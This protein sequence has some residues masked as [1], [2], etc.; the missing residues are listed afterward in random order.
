LSITYVDSDTNFTATEKSLVVSKPANT[1]DNDLM[2][3]VG[4]I[5]HQTAS[6]NPPDGWN[7]IYS[8]A[9]TGHSHKQFVWYKIASSEGSDYTF[10]SSSASILEFAVGIST[11]R[12]I[13]IS[14]A[15][16]RYSV[17][18]TNVTEFNHIAP[19]LTTQS[20]N[21]VVLSIA[22]C[23]YGTVYT[24]TLGVPVYNECFD[25]NSGVGN[26]R[27]SITL[28]YASYV[29]IS[30]T[31][32]IGP[33]AEDESYYKASLVE[34]VLQGNSSSS[35]TSS[36]SSSS[37]SKNPSSSSSS[38]TVS[39]SSS[40]K[41][42]SSSSKSLSSSSSSKSSIS[43]SSS[44]RSSS[45][46]YSLSQFGVT[47]TFDKELSL[48]IGDETHYLYGQ[49]ANDD[50]W[51][52]SDTG[53]V[54]I[55]EISPAKT[56]I[57]Q[58]DPY[59]VGI[60][61]VDGTMID[62]RGMSIGNTGY[63]GTSGTKIYNLGGL[64]RLNKISGWIQHNTNDIV[65]MKFTASGYSSYTETYCLV[66]KID[67]DNVTLK[68]MDGVDI[69]YVSAST[70]QATTAQGLD[71]R[72]TYFHDAVSIAAP[73][74]LTGLH[75]VVTA[76]S[77]RFGEPYCPTTSGNSPRPAIKYNAVLT[78]VE[79]IPAS[80]EFR[81]AYCGLSTGTGAKITGLNKS[82]MSGL[83]LPSLPIAGASYA[84]VLSD[85]LEV[86]KRPWLDFVTT[87]SGEDLLGTESCGAP[88]TD[89]TSPTYARQ[90]TWREGNVFM[91]LLLDTSS[92]S[93]LDKN[94]LAIQM[95]QRGIDIYGIITNGGGWGNIGG[96]IGQ[97]RKLPVLFAGVALDYAPFKNVGV[98]HGDSA[99]TLMKHCRFMEDNQKF[100]ISEDDIINL[101][102][103]SDIITRTNC[104]VTEV[105]FNQYLVTDDDGGDFSIADD[106]VSTLKKREDSPLNFDYWL[107][108]GYESPN[109]EY[110]RVYGCDITDD[111]YPSGTGLSKV[112]VRS[113]LTPGTGKKVRIQLYPSDRIGLPD[114]AGGGS[115]GHYNNPLNDAES[116]TYRT[117]CTGC[118]L[119]GHQLF[120]LIVKDQSNINTIKDLWNWDPFFDYMDWYMEVMKTDYVALRDDSFGQRGT[121]FQN[122]MWDAYRSDYGPIWP[123]SSSS[124]SSK[125]S[126]SRSSSS[127]SSRSSSSKSSS[128]RSSSSSSSRSSSSRSSSS[129]SSKSSSSKSSSSKSSSSKSSS[130]SSSKSSSSKSSSSSSLRSISS[131]SSKSSSKS[132]AS[133]SSSSRS[134]SSSTSSSKSSYS[135]TPGFSS[136]S[137]SPR[138]EIEIAYGVIPFNPIIVNKYDIIGSQIHVSKEGDVHNTSVVNQDDI[139]GHPI[140]LES[141]N[142][143]DRYIIANKKSEIENPIIVNSE[144]MIDSSVVIGEEN[145]VESSVQIHKNVISPKPI[146]VKGIKGF[147]V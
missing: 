20:N 108:W 94:T 114:W 121:D 67:D 77:W 89:T 124:S 107:V 103:T 19:T 40:S 36:K 42:S 30:A 122:A 54:T 144:H 123:G 70:W 76:K 138:I 5:K 104:S 49:Y 99:I 56:I 66:Q 116:R 132:S 3:A 31:G 44:S 52:Y 128:S 4:A 58:T 140:I 50:Y 12:G 126:S 80:G 24:P 27:L 101:Q 79:S 23:M 8:S 47:W 64:A 136:S 81:P 145:H 11:F 137:L 127:S 14:S 141:K 28:S 41:S 72:C 139:E 57:E 35:S 109:P 133:S 63:I 95:V 118:S 87:F 82:S 96:G 78:T 10:T 39:S 53:S 146:V 68:T 60:F 2:V 62:P 110:V 135:S 125:S 83:S 61:T 69:P 26:S 84:P 22:S 115:G 100:Y 15:I 17:S 111:I 9:I 130:S 131:S 46:M 51:V 105:G 37:S 119:G 88:I 33:T 48:T 147:F 1:I 85:V 91:Y 7:L 97:G 92:I 112:V 90:N 102:G 32:D 98:T 142:I 16:G 59:P 86:V 134:K 6:I 120:A 71:S 21:N 65:F 113:P 106:G 25:F 45:I 117:C 93:V 143:K 74:T 34:I 29:S 55:T 75:S 43:S 18:T 129:S 13:N 73:I 38:R